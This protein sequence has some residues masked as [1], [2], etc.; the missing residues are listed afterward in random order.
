M[1]WWLW[2][3]KLVGLL[4]L[5]AVLSGAWLFRADLARL[6][7]PRVTQLAE[8]V[9]G[10]GSGVGP[11]PAPARPS[12]ED[13]VDSLQGWAEDSVLL[14]AR[15]MADLIQGGLPAE[16]RAHIDSLTVRLGADRVTLQGRVDTRSIPRSALGFLAGALE[17]WEHVAGTGVVVAVAPGQAEWR[18]DGLTLRG[19]TLP[20]PAS[21]D[22]LSRAVPGLRDGVV[23]FRLP[24]GVAALKVRATGVTLYRGARR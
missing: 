24:P 8:R 19:F 6:V 16:A 20:A 22:L 4:V 11:R 17:P 15:E 9:Q 13:K 23:P 14:S 3:F 7:R 21:R 12:V 10:L 2:P 5:A 1:R 18:V